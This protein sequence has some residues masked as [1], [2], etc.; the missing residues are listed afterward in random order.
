MDPDLSIKTYSAKKETGLANTGFIDRYSAL[1]AER[2]NGGPILLDHDEHSAHPSP[3]NTIFY[4]NV[5]KA[6]TN[7]LKMD[8]HGTVSHRFRST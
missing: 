8:M 7:S 2:G 3:G 4:E 5:E 1:P 6:G